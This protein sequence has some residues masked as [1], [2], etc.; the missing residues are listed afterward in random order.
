VAEVTS[1]WRDIGK[2]PISKKTPAG[3]SARY[4]DDYEL[5]QA[6]LQKL[7]SLSGESVDWKKVEVSSKKILEEKSKDLLV[8]SYACRALFEQRG[9]QG[10]YDGLSCLKDIVAEFWPSLFPAKKRMRARINALTWLAETQGAAVAQ[11][12]AD[13]GDGELVQACDER[14]EALEGLLEEKIEEGFPGLGDLRR[15]LREQLERQSAGAPSPAPVEE[16]KPARAEPVATVATTAVIE[17]LET[18]EDAK[19]ALRNASSAI[20]KVLAFTRGQD[21]TNPSTYRINRALLWA[22]IDTS[23]PASDG[24]TRIPPPPDQI[25]ERLMSLHDN[26]AWQQLVA[27]VEDRIW[28]FPFWLDLHRMAHVALGNQGEE[29]SGA[30]GAVDSEVI[31]LLTRLPEV[32]D[33]Q[34]ADGTPFADDASRDWISKELLTAQEGAEQPAA[35]AAEQP[36]D[37]AAL[38]E[39]VRVLRKK[40]KIDEAVGL[41]ER[42]MRVTPRLRDRFLIQF[43]LAKLLS[44]TGHLKPA[45][46]HLESIDRQM[47]DFTLESWDPELSS[48][49]LHSYWRALSEAQKTAPQGTGSD[50]VDEVYGRLCRLDTVAGLKLA[51]K[52]GGRTTRSK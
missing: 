7:E 31:T 41:L 26:G 28:E 37:V 27:D 4:D 22:E 47:S 25:Q 12:P 9:Y 45:L 23:P 2:T 5:L 52:K 44:D 38:A 21:P 50:R 14:L 10:L 35:P 46:A 11:R 29:Y 51:R 15:P 1:E 33:L 18:P 48:E 42:E 19:R 17:E 36:E 40:K 13:A 30:K 32:V 16:E 20:K 34:F 3:E 49:I 6:E 39:Q 24:V 8:A 43:E